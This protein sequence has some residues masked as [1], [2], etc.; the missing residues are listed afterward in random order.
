[1]SRPR[2]CS[3]LRKP[4]TAKVT[5]KMEMFEVTSSLAPAP[6]YLQ[7]LLQIAN[8][9]CRVNL[10]SLIV[11]ACYFTPIASSQDHA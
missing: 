10:I 9:A 4:L 11:R 7:A 2:E 5:R 1:M 6:G 3:V 8:A